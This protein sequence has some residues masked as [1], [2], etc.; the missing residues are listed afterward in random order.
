MDTTLHVKIETVSPISLSSGQADVTVD[1]DV[2]HDEYGLP[3]FPA[4]RFKGLLYESAIEVVEMSE[5]CK[6]NYVTREAVNELF[7]RVAGSNVQMNIHDFHLENYDEMIED[8]KC[9]EQAYKECIQ[10]SDVLADYTSLRYQTS[11]DEKTGVAA[12]TSL[13]NMRVVNA[14]IVFAGEIRLCDVETAHID[15]VVWALQN[16]RYAGLKRNRGFG[17]IQ[18]MV[19][20]KEFTEKLG[21]ESGTAVKSTGMSSAKLQRKESKKDKAEKYK[22]KMKKRTANKGQKRGKRK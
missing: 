16:L 21:I 12:D 8:L 1:T 17:K 11:I 15:A 22:N 9:V 5:L 2:I 4:K 13:H 18:C 7:G 19:K 14:G 20:E 3:Y 6:G 10:P